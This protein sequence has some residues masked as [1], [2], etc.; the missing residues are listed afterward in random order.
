MWNVKLEM[1]FQEHKQLRQNKIG[2]LQGKMMFLRP[3]MTYKHLV[4]SAAWS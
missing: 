3:L 1:N 2:Y 4:Y